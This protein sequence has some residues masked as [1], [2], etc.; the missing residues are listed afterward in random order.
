MRRYTLSICGRAYVV[1]VEELGHDRFTVVLDGQSYEVTLDA[2]EQGER[3]AVTPHMFE[4][5]PVQP[6]PPPHPAPTPAAPPPR[7]TPQAV[8]ASRAAPTAGAGV[9]TAPMPGTILALEVTPG[10]Q[11]RRGDP[12]L[13]LEAMKMQN[14]I[15]APADAV[16]A[17]I[18]AQPGQAVG[19]GE[20]LM[21]FAAGG[22]E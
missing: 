16:V 6:P 10:Q 18:L 12:L 21:R 22:Y 11:V 14:I 17:E 9:L 8:P 2:A 19:F 15:R 7:S 5:F 20:P 1:E 3:A 4:G 13:V